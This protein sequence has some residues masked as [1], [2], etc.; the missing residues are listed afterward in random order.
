MALGSSLE[1]QFNTYISKPQTLFCFSW[2]SFLSFFLFLKIVFLVKCLS[3]ACA[4]ECSTCR[5]QKGHQIPWSWSH[6]QLPVSS[7]LWWGKQNWSAGAASALYHG[8]VSHPLCSCF[9]GLDTILCH[10][11]GKGQIISTLFFLYK[12]SRNLDQGKGVCVCTILRIASKRG[13]A[14]LQIFASC[15]QFVEQSL[16]FGSQCRL[17]L[18]LPPSYSSFRT[19]G[20][21]GLSHNA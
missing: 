20:V 19:P 15:K 14:K 12:S 1:Q 17:V 16:G 21:T 4:H 6:G 10:F 8:A 7:L 2:I 13:Q 18:K 3:V 9:D 11:R 5:F